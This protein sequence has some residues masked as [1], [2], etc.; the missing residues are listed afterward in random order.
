MKIIL[1]NFKGIVIEF[2]FIVFC[3]VFIVLM[4]KKK[5]ESKNEL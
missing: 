5:S 4:F 1:I 2:Y 3:G